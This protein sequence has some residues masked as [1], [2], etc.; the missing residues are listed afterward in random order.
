MLALLC[1]YLLTATHASEAWTN[2]D[3]QD[4][5]FG[6]EE[7]IRDMHAKVTEIWQEMKQRR[8][9]K[10]DSKCDRSYPAVR[11]MPGDDM[12]QGSGGGGVAGHLHVGFTLEITSLV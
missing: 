11:V 3:P 12:W 5:G 2:P 6:M 1:A 10:R 4:P 9:A 7:Q 8:A